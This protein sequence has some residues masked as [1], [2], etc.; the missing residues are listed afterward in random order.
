MFIEIILAL[1]VGTLAGI[2]TGLA[3]GIHINLVGAII[4]SLS[5]SF[6]S[7]IPAI[8]LVVFI[9]SMS[10]TH[11]FIDFIPSIFLG[12]PKDGTELSI[13]PGHEM[14]R[15]GLGFQ[16]VKLTSLG[17]LYGIFIFI[18]MA[19]PL[20]LITKSIHEFNMTANLIPVLLIGVSLNLILVE[21]RKLL[22]LAVFLISGLLGLTVLNM[23][24]KEPLLPLLT[25]LFGTSSLLLAI[26]NKTKIKKQE[27]KKII[28]IKRIKPLIT[29]A[30][31]SPL[32]IFLPAISSGQIAVIGN[33]FSKLN[34][35]EFLFMLGVINVLAMAFSF[36]ALFL[37]SKTRT[38]SA[39]AVESLVGIPETRIFIL[40]I[41][42]VLFSGCLA[43][44][45]SGILAKKFIKILE[46]MDYAKVCIIT[47]L[48]ISIITLAVSGF[49]GLVVLIVSTLT[50]VYC[51]S[52]NVSRVNMMGCLLLQTILFYLL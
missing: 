19:M 20:S 12:A 30:I 21:K 44:F 35:K 39:A 15:Q 22:G 40:I 37:I 6:L 16:A 7:D 41:L 26:K 25:G 42:V 36:L 2:F 13:L 8:Y 28:K 1:L 3:P 5:I 4:V 47:L 29:S 52:L 32:S 18:L 14:L 17:C 11:V 24:M 27:L 34:K 43:F 46:K 49:F 51:I 50:G 33:Q 31:T 9:V 45:I 10:I 38:G 23:G 48:V